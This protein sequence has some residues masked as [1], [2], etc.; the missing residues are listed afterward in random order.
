M[1]LPKF[2]RG[3]GRGGLAAAGVTQIPHTTFPGGTSFPHFKQAAIYG[4]LYS[5]W[6]RGAISPGFVIGL[7]KIGG[8][9]YAS[10][11]MATPIESGAYVRLADGLPST[12]TST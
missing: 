7:S 8:F 10:Y 11:W 6:P 2:A 12:E 5:R 9:G 1:V 4:G 3:A